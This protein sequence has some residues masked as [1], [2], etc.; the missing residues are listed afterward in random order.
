MS[1]GKRS[2]AQLASRVLTRELLGVAIGE[3]E[4][5]DAVVRQN[6]R[7]GVG[8]NSKSIKKLRIAFRRI[9]Y[10]LSTMSEVDKS[11]DTKELVRQLRRVGRPLGRLRDAEVLQL[12]VI[13]ALG[14]RAETPEGAELLGLVGSALAPAREV[15]N[16][17]LDSSEYLAVISALHEFRS[18]LPQDSVELALARGV[19][20]RAVHNSWRSLQR[21]VGRARQN[22]SDANLHSLRISGKRMVYVTKALSGILGIPGEEI[23]DH[24]T[25]LQKF[26]GR[27]HD[28][29]VTALTI[30]GIG[31]NHPNLKDLT[32]TLSAEE[33]RCADDCAR[34]WLPLWGAVVDSHLRRSLLRD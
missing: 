15:A 26:L 24:A 14:P 21:E 33:L 28:R 3:I 16:V 18:G 5:A 7:E 32:D 27:Q 8:G 25:T 23:T 11:I 34:T 12:R 4:I 17:L 1:S 22:P 2:E 29:V 30:G 19:A 13:D 31:G 10:E 9:Q 20:E 6:R